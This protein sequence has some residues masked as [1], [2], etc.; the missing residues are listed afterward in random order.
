M[1]R[2]QP[3]RRTR[4]LGDLGYELA[5][6]RLLTCAACGE[7]RQRGISQA[8]DTSYRWVSSL[9]SDM[10][11][12]QVTDASRQW[13]LLLLPDNLR[14]A[15]MD[16]NQAQSAR[17]Q[18]PS[19][20]THSSSAAAVAGARV[21]AGTATQLLTAL[22]SR[23]GLRL[24]TTIHSDPDAAGLPPLS[25]LEAALY[26]NVVQVSP[27]GVRPGT[28]VMP[29]FVW[30]L[31]LLS[32]GRAGVV[33]TCLH[34]RDTITLTMMI[35]TYDHETIVVFLSC[36]PRVEP[37]EA[38]LSASSSLSV[39]ILGEHWT[40]GWLSW[41]DKRLP[42]HPCLSSLT[43]PKLVT[44]SRYLPEA[45]TSGAFGGT[46]RL[47]RGAT[48]LVIIARPQR[49]SRD[50]RNLVGPEPREKGGGGCIVLLSLRRDDS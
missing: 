33:V 42:L 28:R 49:T 45:R 35:G 26:V 18:K 22:N 13:R 48:Q 1:L 21:C 7:Q 39:L 24:L 2:K 34:K 37:T 3:H 11:L 32:Q 25:L 19:G 14:S 6:L 27:E 8:D 40:P 31:S 38:L 10:E 20:C 17:E 29:L 5:G 9:S 16:T 44:V 12:M 4:F 30:S 41:G 23:Q 46:Q 15:V 36:L 47:P 43:Y 50:H